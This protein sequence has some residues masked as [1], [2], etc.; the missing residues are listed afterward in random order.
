MPEPIT[1]ILIAGLLGCGSLRLSGIGMHSVHPYSVPERMLSPARKARMP[2]I[3][4]TGVST[5]IGRGCV[6]VFRE[7]GWE[8]IGTVRDADCPDPARCPEGIPLESLDLAERGSGASLASRVLE[9]HGCPDVL[10]NNAGILQF[11]PLETLSGDQLAA[12][13][14]VNVF[15]QMEVIRGLVPAMRQRGSGTIANVT[16]LGGTMV[17]PFFAGYNSTKWAMEGL[18]EGLWHEL[19]PFGIRVKAIEPGYVDTAIWGRVLPREGLSVEG[20]DAYRPFMESMVRFEA[21]IAKRSTSRSA[22]AEIFAAV[23]DES[24]RLRYPVAAYARSL[25][26]ARRWL[27]A[28]YMMRFFHERWMGPGA[29]RSLGPPRT[30]G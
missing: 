30:R 26:G 23:I 4:I 6:D 7:R 25:V 5:G 28:P 8:V 10:L 24:D 1:A 2:T 11:G 20:P 13:Y 17:F 16:S 12:L 21:S 9:R 22:A 18:C 29:T 15:G 27:G 14:Q 19:A 3:L